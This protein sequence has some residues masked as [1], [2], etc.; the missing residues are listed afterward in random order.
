MS[1]YLTL[2]AALFVLCPVVSTVGAD[3]QMCHMVYFTLKDNSS[4]AVDKLVAGCKEYLSDHDGMVYFSV[5]VRGEEFQRDVNDQVF[6][7]ALNLVFRNKAAH[8]EYSTHP[9]HMKFIEQFEDNW[10]KVRVFDSYLK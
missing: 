6:E 5:G 3:P 9:R 1:R 10:A 2:L 7:V 8:D 4:A